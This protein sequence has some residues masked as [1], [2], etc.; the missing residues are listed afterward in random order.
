MRTRQNTVT[1]Q[2]SRRVGGFPAARAAIVRSGLVLAVLLFA[3]GSYAAGR[4]PFLKREACELEKA[5]FMG[6]TTNSI[7]SL[8]V[9]QASGYYD[10]EETPALASRLENWKTTESLE[11]ARGQGPFMRAVDRKSTYSLAARLILDFHRDPA[12]VR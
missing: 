10:C 2:R 6:E 3:I 11:W 4:G 7:Q 9:T 12:F 1:I 8:L 5:R